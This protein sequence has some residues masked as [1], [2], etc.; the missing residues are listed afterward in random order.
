MDGM[1]MSKLEKLQLFADEVGIGE[2]EDQVQNGEG[3]D[4]SWPPD[5]ELDNFNTF[6]VYVTS[7][8]NY[9]WQNVMFSSKFLG[10][11]WSEKHDCSTSL[12]GVVRYEN[13]Q[14]VNKEWK[15]VQVCKILDRPIV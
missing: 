12:L 6:Y 5:D 13:E 14:W 9:G 1:K 4:V 15:A 2:D 7:S 11:E 10:E 3:Y 8:Y